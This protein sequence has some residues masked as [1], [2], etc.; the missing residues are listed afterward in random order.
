MKSPRKL[1]CSIGKKIRVYQSFKKTKVQNCDPSS[2]FQLNIDCFE[3]IFDWLSFNDLNSLGQTCK[4]LQQYTLHYMRQN[5]IK[6]DAFS[7]G[8]GIKLSDY[9]IR[10]DRF[11]NFIEKLS[12]Y[13]GNTHQFQYIGSECKSLKEIRFVLI[14]LNIRKISYIKSILSQIESIEIENC[15][16][17]GNFCENFLKFCP[18][19]K[20]LSINNLKIR[21]K[22]KKNWLQPKYPKLEHFELS[23]DGTVNFT[24]LLMFLS[25]NPNI[26]SFATDHDFHEDE[27]YIEPELHSNVKLDDLIILR[28]TAL[29]QLEDSHHFNQLYSQGFYKR[30]HIRGSKLCRYLSNIESATSLKALKT[31]THTSCLDGSQCFCPLYLINLKELNWYD[32]Q[33]CGNIWNIA[34]TFLNLERVSFKHAFLDEILPFVLH[35]SKLKELKVKRYYRQFG[36]N[37]EFDVNGKCFFKDNILDLKALNNERMKLSGACRVEIYVSEE[38]F[39]ATKWAIG[40]TNYHLVGL[41][42]AIFH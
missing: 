19:L 27:L 34:K 17:N 35:S 21:H 40:V 8:D 1:L 15:Y 9:F 42:R 22:N 20:R 24:E 4:R 30:F 25:R 13:Y 5:C 29:Y 12:I 23:H 7:E 41:K 3:A 11:S 14:S 26:N 36:R 28:D 6:I 37:N 2:I 33:M 39:F 16:I 32:P 10:I 31:L 38:V 18:N